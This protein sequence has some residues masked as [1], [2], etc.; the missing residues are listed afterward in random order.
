MGTLD[1]PIVARVRPAKSRRARAK[2][3]FDSRNDR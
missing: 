3:F 2:R 1:Q